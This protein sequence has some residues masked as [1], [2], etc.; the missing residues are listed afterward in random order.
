MKYLKLTLI[1]ILLFCFSLSNFRKSRKLHTRKPEY[2]RIKANINIFKLQLDNTSGLGRVE[3]FLAIDVKQTLGEDNNFSMYIAYENGNGVHSFF[4]IKPKAFESPY[5]ENEKIE[6]LK[7]ANYLGKEVTDRKIK[8]DILGE[9]S[10]DNPDSFVVRQITTKINHCSPNLKYCY[11]PM[12]GTI[13]SYEFVH[14]SSKGGLAID[15]CLSNENSINDGVKNFLSGL[16]EKAKIMNGK[17]LKNYLSEDL[18][19]TDKQIQ[20]KENLIMAR[21]NNIYIPLLVLN[22]VY[23]YNKNGY[24]FTDYPHKNIRTFYSNSNESKILT[25]VIQNY[26]LWSPQKLTKVEEQVK[27][28]IST[29]NEIEKIKQEFL[30]RNFLKN[31]KELFSILVQI[32]NKIL[33]NPISDSEGKYELKPQAGIDINEQINSLNSLIIT[34]V[35]EQILENTNRPEPF[36]LLSLVYEINVKKYLSSLCSINNEQILDYLSME[37]IDPNL[38]KK[39]G[40][41]VRINLFQRLSTIKNGIMSMEDVNIV[42]DECDRSLLGQIYDVY[43]DIPEQHDKEAIEQGKHKKG[44]EGKIKIK[45]HSS[46]DLSRDDNYDLKFISSFNVYLFEEV[47]DKSVDKMMGYLLDYGKYFCPVQVKK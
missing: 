23:E 28:F 6:E 7:E 16:V 13:I 5:L 4:K 26:I 45:K 22:S 24:S 32:H 2:F 35:K 36:G 3:G 37:N 42:C 27:Q 34:I 31:Q 10:N 11:I 21:L 18:Q 8:K 19:I 14:K 17:F 41:V 20:M 40:D 44:L 46:D 15:I 33:T 43:T 38:I 1:L 30:D 39:L 12:L 25:S 47:L 29:N 9:I